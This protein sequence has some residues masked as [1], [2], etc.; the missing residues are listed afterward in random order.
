MESASG[1]RRGGI[2]RHLAATREAVTKWL[3]HENPINTGGQDASLLALSLE[4]DDEEPEQPEVLSILRQSR[5]FNVPC[6]PGTILEW[7]YILL[8]E[9][10][11]AIDAENDYHRRVEINLRKRAEQA[12]KSYG[13]L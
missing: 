4:V 9:L 6:W 2:T 12:T 10:N 11:V 3:E 8:Q 5:R 13:D 1:R 7:P